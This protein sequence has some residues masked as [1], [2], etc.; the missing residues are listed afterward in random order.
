ME[1]KGKLLV[2]TKAG[3]ASKPVQLG[4]SLVSCIFMIVL[5]IWFLTN[6]ET[7][8]RMG[9]DLF[10]NETIGTLIMLLLSIFMIGYSVF[11]MIVNIIGSRS[12][13]AVYE[14]SVVGMTALSMNKPSASMQKFDI[15]YAEIN[16]V[17]ETGKTI[18]IYT[19]Y[20]SYEV[21]AANNRSEA[22]KEIR[23]RMSGKLRQ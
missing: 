9:R 17:T 11:I 13:C 12:Y 4:I 15:S 21:M 18:I 22:L 2:T 7:W 1:N 3:I 10:N 14:N 23:K 19:P 5:G 20:A 16:N 6:M 8:N